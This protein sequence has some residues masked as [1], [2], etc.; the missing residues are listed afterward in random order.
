MP[1]RT[2]AY[3]GKIIIPCK[4]A[5]DLQADKGKLGRS[6]VITKMGPVIRV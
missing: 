2:E 1:H 5:L 6:C 4:R 3:F